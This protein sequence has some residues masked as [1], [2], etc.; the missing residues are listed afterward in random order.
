MRGRMSALRQ[1][2]LSW[3]LLF[4]YS[5]SKFSI[6]DR[7]SFQERVQEKESRL[8]AEALQFVKEHNERHLANE[9]LTHAK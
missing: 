3:D 1:H 4:R 5:V 6:F 2:V 7:R 8:L 9:T